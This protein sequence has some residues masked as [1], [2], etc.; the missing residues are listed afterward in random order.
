MMKVGTRLLLAGGSPMPV[1]L[2][3]ERLLKSELTRLRDLLASQEYIRHV[4][5]FGS[6]AAGAVH[7]WSDLDL[8]IVA[9][10]TEPFT[11]RSVQLSRLTKPSVGVQFLV[12]TPAE[13]AAL[14]N[15]PFIRVEIIEKGKTMPL[16]PQEE[17]GRWL[18]F[19]YEDLRMADLALENEIFNQACFH[20]QQCVEKA[21]E[22][23]IAAAGE[24]LPRTHLLADLWS[25]LPAESRK[26]FAAWEQAILD[27]EQFYIPT[28]YPDA[29]PGMLP[30]GLP[31][32][33]DAEQALA[34][35]QAC[36]RIACNHN[37]IE[38]QS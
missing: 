9:D 19:A 7:E 27:L 35:A 25:N 6:Y 37:G 13:M 10:S 14:R 31:Q 3:R 5:V 20:A 16:R 2:A 36:Y 29:L 15:R 28:R 21:L 38:S 23:M 12:Y 26:Y 34:T 11:R 24:L 32:L 33:E 8:A 18:T 1:A 22:A 30:E 4:T 17:A